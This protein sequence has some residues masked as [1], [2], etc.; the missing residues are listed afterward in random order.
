MKKSHA[1][2]GPV[3][4]VDVDAKREKS[5]RQLCYEKIF[6]YFEREFSVDPI[7]HMG[8]YFAKRSCNTCS[9]TGIVRKLPPPSMLKEA[10]EKVKQPPENVTNFCS[11]GS[12]KGKL[13]PG[14]AFGHIS[15][16]VDRL[17]HTKEPF[18]GPKNPALE[19]NPYMPP[20]TAAQSPTGAGQ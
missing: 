5:A 7:G 6:E 11:G 13:R 2:R 14:C 16:E 15:A 18:V 20:K 17:V 1:P 19:H 12:G 3:P 4:S 10:V 9:G 8:R